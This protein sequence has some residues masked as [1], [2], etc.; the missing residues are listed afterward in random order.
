MSLFNPTLGKQL[1]RLFS[2]ETLQVK[3]TDRY[4]PK[5][6]EEY[7][8]AIQ[9]HF[10]FWTDN[11]TGELCCKYV[12]FLGERPNE[13][14][15]EESCVHKGQAALALLYKYGF[16]DIG[17]F[18]QNYMPSEPKNKEVMA[19]GLSYIIDIMQIA[20]LKVPK[21]SH[22]TMSDIN[23]F[24]RI[25]VYNVLI[26]GKY[27]SL[28]D[29]SKSYEKKPLEDVIAKLKEI[30]NNKL[31]NR[32]IYGIPSHRQASE[33]ELFGPKHNEVKNKP[34]NENFKDKEDDDGR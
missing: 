18:N 21:R 4:I 28:E 6:S 14:D 13:L 2:G 5:E 3:T 23:I 33:D 16:L 27:I 12:Q 17:T 9:R 22:P 24:S 31:V 30:A 1:K 20:D 32:K 29:F 7:K 26:N 19:L 11:E 25:D 34:E 10:T 8:K 15:E